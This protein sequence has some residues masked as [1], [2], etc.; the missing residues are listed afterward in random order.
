VRPDGLAMT[1]VDGRR[2]FGFTVD[3][4]YAIINLTNL[5]LRKKGIQ[6][7]KRH[8][9]KENGQQKKFSNGIEIQVLLHTQ[10]PTI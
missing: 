1:E 8:L 4:E 2:F 5:N 3:W 10:T 9:T 6:W 7:L